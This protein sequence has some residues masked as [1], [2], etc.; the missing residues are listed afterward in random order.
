M[1]Q[2]VGWHPGLSW[3]VRIRIIAKSKRTRRQKYR[4]YERIPAHKISSQTDAGGGRKHWRAG[5]VNAARERDVGGIQGVSGERVCDA[6]VEMCS[7]REAA[8]MLSEE[9][10]GGVCFV[11]GL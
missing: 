7:A 5:N 2:A 11:Q 10:V 3:P 6:R 9:R 8:F 4:P 1:G